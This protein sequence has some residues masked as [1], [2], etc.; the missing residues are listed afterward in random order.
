MLKEWRWENVERGQWENVKRV[1]V[2]KSWEGESGK[3]LRDDMLENVER[4][5][6]GKWIEFEGENCWDENV[7]RGQMGECA[8]VE[9]KKTLIGWRWQN[10]ESG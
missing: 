10:V 9:G 3:M 5:K 4:V 2:G 8:E 1:K 6:V 7:E